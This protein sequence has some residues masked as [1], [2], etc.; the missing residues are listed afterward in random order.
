MAQ[1]EKLTADYEGLSEQA[2]KFNI[3]RAG[4]IQ[5]YNKRISNLILLG[6]QNDMLDFAELTLSL[7]ESVEFLKIGGTDAALFS[8]GE[9]LF[10]AA[11]LVAVYKD[12]ECKTEAVLNELAAV[13]V[14][15]NAADGKI[16]LHISAEDKEGNAL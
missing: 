7:A 8:E 16:S 12:F 3:Y 9:G 4:F 11:E 14:V 2:Y 6:E 15:V 10:T 13:M 5:T 1:T